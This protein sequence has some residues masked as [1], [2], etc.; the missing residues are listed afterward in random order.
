MQ[1]YNNSYILVT[2]D[3][4]PACH[5]KSLSC[6]NANPISGRKEINYN[7][8]YDTDTPARF[9]WSSTRN[10]SAITI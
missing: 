2:N 10:K 8:G 3:F 4:H 5:K 6:P 7:F 9:P 1:F